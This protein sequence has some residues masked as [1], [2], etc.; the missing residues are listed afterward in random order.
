[1]MALPPT[2]GLSAG[3]WQILLTNNLECARCV[4][5]RVTPSVMRKINLLLE[6]VTS[7]P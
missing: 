7:V 6:R 4:G 1:M 2:C 5:A 3:N